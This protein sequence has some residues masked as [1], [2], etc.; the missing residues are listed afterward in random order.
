MSLRVVS[1]FS[2]IGGLDL[3]LQRAGH[4]VIQMSEDWAPASRVLRTR[5]HDVP[6]A[7][8]VREFH[9]AD[10]YDLLAAG[11]PCTDLSQA[12]RQRGIFGPSSGLVSEVFRLVAETS[13]EWILLENV[14]NLL[15]LGRGAGTAYI[16][17][18]LAALGYSWAYRV[19][20]S[21]FTGLPQRRRVFV[22]ASRSGS[23]ASALLAD[24]AAP[25]DAMP[26]SSLPPHG[27]YWTEGRRGAAVVADAV[28]T[29][30]GGSTLGL[31]SAPPVWL[32]TAAVGS[33]GPLRRRC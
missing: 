24:D 21:R 10:E 3:G 27:S 6:L 33:L 8:D 5:F 23:P 31:P 28:P 4:R 17:D 30:K 11:F 20:D 32:P 18:R 14:P 1:L 12:G 2:G 9:A 15:R 16:V 25:A 26:L 13:P 22:L 19:L 7:G 29:L